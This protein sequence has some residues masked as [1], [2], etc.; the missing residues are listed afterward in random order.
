MHVPTP[1]AAALA[2]LAASLIAGCQTAP[3]GQ[4]PSV[5]VAET[6]QEAGWRR[7]AS[8]ADAGRLDRLGA[9]WSEA[10][11][12]ARRGGFA[13]Q[14][15]AEGPLLAPGTALPRAAPSP[16][17]YRCRLIRLGAAA[18]RVKAYRAYSPFFCHVG[19]EGDLLSITKQTGS[20]RPGG[21]LWQSSDT[22]LVFLGSMALGNEEVPRAYGEDPK[23]DMA[24]V[25]ER[26]APFRW[27]LVIPWPQST[28][29]LDVFELTPVEK[30][31]G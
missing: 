17:S 31:P 15:G 28:S 18:P 11:A 9:A 25:L 6:G 23:R 5:T 20:Q 2:A 27:R 26:I 19:V 1:I 29:K 7:I 14:I 13:R 16:G 24:G 30:Q 3:T 10:L 22:R 4:R 12:E 8:A 21:Y